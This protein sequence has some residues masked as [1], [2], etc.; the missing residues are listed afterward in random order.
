MCIP[1]N[2]SKIDMDGTIEQ[3]NQ[4]ASTSVPPMDEPEP[5]TGNVCITNDFVDTVCQSKETTQQAS[6]YAPSTNVPNPEVATVRKSKLSAHCSP[7]RT[8]V[9]AIHPF[10]ML[11]WQTC[12]QSTATQ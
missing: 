9:V 8:L 1:D 7:L 10:S 11:L 4:Q 12:F 2:A 3:T 6:I 5:G